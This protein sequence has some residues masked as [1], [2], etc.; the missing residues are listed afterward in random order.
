MLKFSK[1]RT[2]FPRSK[3]NGCEA[4]ASLMQPLRWFCSRAEF[5]LAAYAYHSVICTSLAKSPYESPLSRSVVETQ[6]YIH[7]HALIVWLRALLDR[8]PKSLAIGAIA[9]TGRSRIE[10]E[11]LLNHLDAYPPY[12]SVMSRQDRA[13]TLDYIHR[14]A[15]VLSEEY[16]D[17]KDLHPLAAKAHLIRRMANK[18]VAHMTLDDYALSGEDLNDMVMAITTLALA[19]ESLINERGRLLLVE[20]A[21]FE[22]ARAMF[23]IDIDVE[24]RTVNFILS[25]LPAWISRGHEG[26]HWPSLA[27]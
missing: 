25:M 4:S 14:W 17:G 21:S 10:R 6:D 2:E 22:G 19:V 3:D 26:P 16:Q 1:P 24:P 9:K 13:A 8:N 27:P 12:K 18:T 5:V 15:E 23:G 20:R 7:R 11:R